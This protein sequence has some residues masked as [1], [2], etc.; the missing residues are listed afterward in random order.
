MRSSS[1]SSSKSSFSWLW[2][3]PNASRRFK[4][5]VSLH[6]HT[7]SSCESL[8]MIPRCTANV[9]WLGVAIRQQEELYYRNKGFRLDFNQAYWTPPLNPQGAWNLERTQLENVLGVTGLVSLTDHD[10]IE[11]PS[12]LSL[13]GS[14]NFLPISVEWT[15]PF[16]PTFFH[17]GIHNLP[18]R[19][20]H[21]IMRE[22]AAFTA[23]PKPADLGGLL[24]S[25]HAM[26][27]VLIVLNHPLWD[28]SGVGMEVHNRQLG[29]LL[30]RH[31][32]RFHALEVNG[33]RSWKENA[34]VIRLGRDAGYPVIS[35]GDRHG[36]EPNAIVNLTNAATF[37]EFVSEVREDQVS[38]TLFMTQ[39]REPLRSRI[40]QT[41]FDIVRDYPEQQG[42]VHWNDRIFFRYPDGVVRPLVEIWKGKGPAVVQ[43]FLWLLR[44]VKN[45]RIRGALRMALNDPEEFAF[46][47]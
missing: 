31:G 5:G 26:K 22:L 20:A 47:P 6:S 4:T 45:R 46:E 18:A 3:L 21:D 15:I 7:S 12:L 25:L 9:P 17:L 39:Y 28:E 33:L 29:R 10:T 16:G 24:D 2:T 13:S 42:R 44:L 40:V 41:M 23:D 30:E 27:Q 34:N 43:R 19:R 14:G 36:C 8:G 32:N 38:E 11:A 37:E 1:K 35:G